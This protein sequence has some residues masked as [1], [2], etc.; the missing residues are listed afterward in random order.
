MTPKK[1]ELVVK[2]QSALAIPTKRGLEVT[3]EQSDIVIPRTQLLQKMS[4]IPDGMKAGWIIN[5]LTREMLPAE[6]VPIMNLYMYLRFNSKDKSKPGFD[7]AFEPG[8]LMW[9]TPSPTTEQLKECEF[10][11]DGEAPLAQKQI[12]FLSYF[13]GEDIP[14]MLNFSKTS[15]NAGKRLL[16]LAKYLPGD[17]WDYKYK[18]ASIEEHKNGNDYYVLK[19]TPAGKS[20]EETRQHAIGLYTQFKAMNVADKVHAEEE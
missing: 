9:R 12:C 4:E 16:T 17:I 7:S 15:Y 10:G 6:F 13:M 2:E 8:Q 19:V 20:D 18:L 14:V 5:S 3:P 11:P 1:D